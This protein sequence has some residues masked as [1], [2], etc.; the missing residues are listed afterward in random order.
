M[1]SFHLPIGAV[2]LL[3]L[4]VCGCDSFHSRD[5]LHNATAN[6]WMV[7]TKFVSD[8]PQE[9]RHAPETFVGF[10]AQ[11]RRQELPK[12]A[13]IVARSEV[14]SIEYHL[15]PEQLARLRARIGG[16]LRLV[17]YDEGFAVIVGD[18]A[19][20]LKKAKSLDEYNKILNRNKLRCL[21]FTRNC[22]L[23]P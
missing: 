2:C 14:E 10:T 8:A 21:E 17:L 18:L 5:S 4:V 23:E 22:I 15:S 13:A 1:R 6:Y 20:S 19:M 16:E 11:A 7:T 9:Y 12:L 3:W